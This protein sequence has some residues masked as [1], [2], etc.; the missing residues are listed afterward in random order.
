MNDTADTVTFRVPVRSDESAEQAF[1]ELARKLNLRKS[2]E[3][4]DVKE[5]VCRHLNSDE[6]GKWLL[7]I[8]N[9][10]DKDLVIGSV[11]KPGL[12]EYLPQ[13][14]NGIIL[15][16]TRSGQ[17]AVEF[18]QS[19]VIDIAQMDKTDATDLLQKSLIRKELLQDEVL[20]DELLTRLT[21]LPLAVTQVAAYL[22]QTEAPIQTY[23]KLLQGADDDVTRVL[24]KE[25]KNSTR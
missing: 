16:T 24:G 7:V 13:S 2:S 11:D 1:A 14:E 22:Y 8:D 18:A 21:F 10:D 4:E 6:A 23:L 5:L 9:A 15:L 3:D 25:F 12:E 19:D 17:V 20:I